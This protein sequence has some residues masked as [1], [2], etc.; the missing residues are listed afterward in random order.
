M[1]L[2]GTK[3][4]RDAGVAT[5]LDE[6]LAESPIGTTLSQLLY[7]ISAHENDFSSHDF[8]NEDVKF[9]FKFKTN[10][11]FTQAMIFRELD[12]GRTPRD[13][14]LINVALNIDLLKGLSE[15]CDPSPEEFKQHKAQAM[16]F[17][18]RAFKLKDAYIEKVK[19]LQGEFDFL[20]EEAIFIKR[21]TKMHDDARAKRTTSPTPVPTTPPAPRPRNAEPQVDERKEPGDEF[22][23]VSFMKNWYL[24]AKKK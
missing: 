21:V 5:G 11:L 13:H 19:A 14:P 24:R 15:L 17:A 20:K 22:E 7:V 6:D 23:G 2:Q 1:A 4:A 10:P 8:T 16:D 9:E 12:Q 3:R 18:T